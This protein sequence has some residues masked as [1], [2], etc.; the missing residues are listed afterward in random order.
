MAYT[1]TIRTKPFLL[2]GQLNMW[3]AMVAC[4]M[5]AANSTYSVMVR[6]IKDFNAGSVDPGFV[7]E[8]TTDLTPVG[9]EELVMKMLDDLRLSEARAIQIEFT[10]AP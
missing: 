5:A 2:A 7:Q 10:D 9:N 8:V 6:L 3:G 4:L 1:A